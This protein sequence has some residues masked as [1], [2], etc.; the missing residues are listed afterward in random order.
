VIHRDVE[1]NRVDNLLTS[2]RD[3]SA[4]EIVRASAGT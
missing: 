4:A 1:G 2:H 3:A